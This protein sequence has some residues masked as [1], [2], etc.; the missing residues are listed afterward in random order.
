MLKRC[1]TDITCKEKIYLLVLRKYQE[2]VYRAEYY[3]IVQ[4]MYPFCD[5]ELILHESVKMN[6]TFG[7]II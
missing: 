2:Y 7:E 4:R 5:V 6:F 1:K 3:H